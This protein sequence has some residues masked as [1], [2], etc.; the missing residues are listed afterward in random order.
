MTK[1]VR[2]TK[3]EGGKRLGRIRTVTMEGFPALDERKRYE[4]T[5]GAASVVNFRVSEGGRLEKRWGSVC[6]LT[7][8]VPPRAVYSG[9]LA[10]EPVTYF[11]AGKT[12]YRRFPDDEYGLMTAGHVKT[13]EGDAAF[14]ALSGRLWLFDGDDVYLFTDGEG[15]CAVEGYIP[16]YGRDWDALLQGEV[17][18]SE[19]YLTPRVRLHYRNEKAYDTL[20]FGRRVLSIHRVFLDGVETAKTEIEL[21]ETGYACIGEVLRTAKEIELLVTLDGKD[22]RRTV[23][24]AHRAIAYGGAE[25]NRLLLW[26]ADEKE[27]LYFSRV[28]G[29]A[30]AEKSDSVGKTTGG[31]LYFPRGE[32]ARR[33]DAPVTAVCRYG[34][35]LLVFT[36]TG[37]FSASFSDESLVVTPIHS[38][39]G[40]DVRDCAALVGNSPVSLSGGVLW[41]WDLRSSSERECN[42]SPLSAPVASLVRSL[43]KSG[44]TLG[45]YPALSELF[46]AAGGDSDGR[47]LVYNADG[48]CFYL[49]EGLYLDRLVPTG[50]APAFLSGS[51]LL[52][53]DRE[54]TEDADGRTIAARYESGLIALDAPL[55]RKRVSSLSLL[56]DPDSDEM[57]VRVEGETGRA[58]AFSLTGGSTGVPSVYRLFPSLG[59]SR[60]FRFSIETEGKRRPTAGTLTLTVRR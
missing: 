44:V 32:E 12:V 43:P 3:A 9:Y 6:D 56:A 30:E 23:A 7:L 2:V 49:Y 8:P 41:R 45:Y 14:V 53:L 19:N 50:E 22:E 17:F 57:T 58:A 13:E 52:R 18:E 38:T 20:Y 59:R 24:S 4:G 10:G 1:R 35:R 27:A 25:D 15:F 28:V 60:S 33:V 34:E 29:R 36:A 51:V 11:L 5:E 46:V 40:C 47:V 31:A 16:L 48:D 37:A 55:L 26:D 39:V 42:A 21:T 54:A